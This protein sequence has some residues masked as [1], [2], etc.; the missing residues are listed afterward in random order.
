MS[1]GSRKSWIHCTTVALSLA[2]A[3]VACTQAQTPGPSPGSAPAQ[4]PIDDHAPVF[5]PFPVS[6]F[7]EK[8]DINSTF[9][10]LR[11]NHLHAGLD[12]ATGAQVG[13]AVHAP[14]DGEIDRLRA[15][16]VGY[17]R[18]IYLQ[19][20]DGRL[21]VFGHL[22]AFAEPFAS[23]VEHVQDSSGL[24]EQDLWPEDGRFPVHAGDIIGWTGRSGTGSP[25]LHI[26]IRRGDMAI[27]PLR[28]GLVIPDSTMPRIVRVTL[29]PLDD[30]SAVNGGRAPVTLAIGTRDSVR[31]QGHGRLRVIVEALDAQT[32]GTYDVAAWRVRASTSPGDEWVEVRYDSVSWATDMSQADF[33]YDRGRYTGAGRSS[34]LLAMPDGRLPRMTRTSGTG[35]ANGAD[36]GVI[37]LDAAHPSVTL[38]LE[39]EDLAAHVVRRTVLLTDGAPPAS[40]APPDSGTFATMASGAT[41]RIEG[42]GRCTVPP[43]A[44]FE[45]TRLQF[46]AGA[47]AKATGELEPVGT[48]IVV[49]P[50]TTPLRLPVEIAVTVPA[51]VAFEK[52]G[53]Y[54]GGGDGW[55]LAGDRAELAAREIIASTRRLG[56]FA[57]FHDVKAPRIVLVRPA[58]RAPVSPYPRWDLEARLGEAGSGIDASKTY[59]AVDGRRV[60]SEW[61]EVK[62]TLRWRP[63]HVPVTGT[64]EV[65]VVATDRAG[66]ERRT[67]GTFVLR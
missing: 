3:P 12:L 22:D 5:P 16:G 4:P 27:N 28:A 64:H 18:S 34:V 21:V 1:L 48:P 50:A 8:L 47:P 59:L 23:F 14:M 62:N 6:V 56:R 39:A 49:A 51:G 36:A 40:P 15:S 33:V 10:D 57:L 13:R 38:A 65:E 66:N 37:R 52:L 7:D 24:Y 42:V 9:G 29:A 31:A 63:L 67:A 44:L 58:S 43:G 41:P 54:R 35:G 55:E 32:D 2:L 30:I 60:P 46:R 19:T 11:S 61:D 26:E 20:T 53:L 25:H 45:P 17:G